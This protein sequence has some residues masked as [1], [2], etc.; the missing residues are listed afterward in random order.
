MRTLVFF[1]N[2]HDFEP[3]PIADFPQRVRLDP[4]PK[5]PAET[6]H[7]FLGIGSEPTRGA[8]ARWTCGIHSDQLV[9]WWKFSDVA[10]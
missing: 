6:R 1:P 9:L 7:P 4:F 10:P 8:G 2:I 5:D 3:K